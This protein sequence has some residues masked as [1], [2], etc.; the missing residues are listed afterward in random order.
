MTTIRSHTFVSIVGLALAL[1]AGNSCSS[2]H[3]TRPASGGAGGGGMSA[4]GTTSAFG[5][6]TSSGGTAGSGGSTGVTTGRGGSTGSGGMAASGG[7]AKGGA[8]GRDAGLGG[9]TGGSLGR[10]GESA[11]GGAATDGGSSSGGATGTLPS[12]FVNGYDGERPTTTSFDIGWKFHLG[13]ASGAQAEEFD[14]SSWRALNVPHDWSIELPFS[15]SSAASSGGGYLDG[16]IGWYRKTFT[17]P[18]SSDGSRFFLQFD[19]IYMDSTVWVNGAQVGGRP[20]GY[21]SFEMDITAAVHAGGSNVVAVKVNNQLP[22]SRWYSGSGI[23][24]HV[25]LKMVNPVHVAYCGAWVTTPTVGTNSATV[26]VSTQI[27]NEAGTSQSVYVV[28]SILAPDGAEAA[29]DQ[30]TASSLAAG[31]SQTFTQSL[32]VSNPKLW[33]TTSPALYA[34]KIQV[35]ANDG[36]VDTYVT[37][38]GIRS[39][40]FEANTGFSL[41]DKATK[42]NGVCMHHDLGSLGAALNDRALERQL[43]ILKA[44]GT[45]GIRTSHNPPAPELL[46]L[47]D[48]MGFVVMDEAFDCWNKAKTSHDYA[49]FFSNWAQADVQDMVARD[50][51]HPSVILWS[52]GNEIPDV[53]DIATAQKLINWVKDK[54]STRPITQNMKPISEET[55]ALEDLL[56][57]SYSALDYTP[58]HTNHPTWKLIA[59]ESSSAVRSRGVYHLPVNQ[60]VLTSSD[61]QCSSY[62][63]SVVSWGNSAEDSWSAVNTRSY[64]AGE[65]VWTGFDYIGEPTP[66]NW[67]AKS[68][69][70]GIVDTAGFPKDIYYFYQSKWNSSGPPMVHIVPMDW[71]S[72]S[73]GQSVPVYVYTNCTSVELL[74][75]GQSLGSKSMNASTGHLRWDVTFASGTLRAQA[76]ND[77]EAIAYDEVQTAGPAAKIILKVDRKHISANGIDLAFVE[78]D[79]TDA[80]DVLVPQASQKIDFTVIGPGTIVAVDNGNPVSLEAY[81]AAS[82][83]AFNGKALAIVQSTSTPGAISLQATSR[84]LTSGSIDITA[85][86]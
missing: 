35:L 47:A 67:P 4:P 24:R 84:G 40:K 7:T 50:R 59:S 74:L 85:G 82:R 37:R 68:S 33:S 21:S 41:N 38:F 53:S 5:G 22:S 15:Q 3:E 34:V 63:N 25:W 30:A 70:F 20:Y 73:A 16:G 81:K 80:N 55:A 49:R 76:S 32:S 11:T 52:I 26:K 29:T 14:D 6:V 27:K 45:N 8:S 86:P 57:F 48:R 36:V 79:V 13:D 62:D 65:F 69:Y 2:T 54:D 1:A 58:Y 83:S 51:N 12:P 28:T 18:A 43:E 19:G 61:N 60:N 56:G 66:Y 71:T 23:Y 42:I 31:G 39:F 10:G 72:W 78:A 46:Q 75:N 17:I 64:M 9:S 77:G 44:M